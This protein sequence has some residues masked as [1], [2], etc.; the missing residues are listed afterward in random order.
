MY[1]KSIFIFRRDYRLQDNLGLIR[2]LKESKQVL[3]I[4]ILTPEQ[5]DDNKND[6]KSNNAVQFMIESLDDLDQALRKKNSKL[7]YFYDS[8]ENAI[9][10]L[11]LQNAEI[12]AVF[13]NLDYSPY[14]TKRDQLILNV[15]GENDVDFIQEHDALL[16]PVGNIRTGSGTYYSKF[17]PFFNKAK[18]ESVDSVKINLRSNYVKATA[19]INDQYDGKFSEFYEHN[20]DIWQ[21]GGRIEAL[22]LLSQKSLNFQKKY[23]I[24]RNDLTGETTNLSAYLKFGCISIREVYHKFKKTLGTKNDLIKQLYWRDF[25]HNILYANP[26]VVGSAMKPKYNQLSWSN[27][28]EHFKKW[29]DGQTGYPVIDAAMRSMNE[30]GY[31]HNRGRLIVS[32]FL[33]KILLIDWRWG[34]KY[35]SQKLSDIDIANNNG[36]W[37]WGASTGAD[38]QPYFRIFNPWLQSK[39]F[40]PQGEYIKKWLPEL[41]EVDAKHLHQWDQYVDSYEG[42]NY[43]KPIIDYATGKKLALIAY[44]KLF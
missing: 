5:L 6:Y 30:T 21:H 43:P 13:V 15:C 35:F 22:K 20:P 8:P 4:F 31:M 7:F 11:L 39:K 33:I 25:Y 1:D 44:K 38:S 14:S 24:S 42:I 9:E 19:K 37:Q 3:P 23:N 16:L 40:D 17:T 18:V 26:H 29:C 36:N 2:A 32:N 12:E 28:R 27:N 41:N 10:D 34:E